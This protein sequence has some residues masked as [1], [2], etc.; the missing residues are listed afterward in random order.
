MLWVP[1]AAST[2]TPL[3]SLPSTS[4]A[5]PLLQFNRTS[6]T[7]PL[8]HNHSHNSLPLHC[9]L[10]SLPLPTSIAHPFHH[11]QL[12]HESQ[13]ASKNYRL[14]CTK[15]APSVFSMLLSLVPPATGATVMTTSL[16]LTNA[17]FVHLLP[18]PP[19]YKG[20]TITNHK[21]HTSHLLVQHHWF[22]TKPYLVVMPSP[23]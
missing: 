21:Y 11:H 23:T 10:L 7:S 19:H 5:Q 3:L 18:V 1:L 6:K 2:T 15:N 16:I 14:S 22:P 17:L 20:S 13:H 9:P 8:H 4:F 12:P